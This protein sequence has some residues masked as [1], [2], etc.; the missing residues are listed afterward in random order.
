MQDLV[1]SSINP[2]ELIDRLAERVAEKIS[3]IN[4]DNQTD[5]ITKTP[6]TIDSNE[7]R[8]RLLITPPTLAAMRKRGEIPFFTVGGQYR[9][10]WEAVLKALNKKGR[11]NVK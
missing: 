2:G 3:S 1:L 4:L 7:L 5:T 10:D 11:F 9:Y 6:E 8:F